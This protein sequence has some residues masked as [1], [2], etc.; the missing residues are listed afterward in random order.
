MTRLVLPSTA[1]AVALIVPHYPITAAKPSSNF[2]DLGHL[3]GGFSD[4]FG[5]VCSLAA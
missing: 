1:L 5:T 4:A 2:V 3:G